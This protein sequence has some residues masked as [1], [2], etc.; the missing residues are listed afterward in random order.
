MD[1]TT[2]ATSDVTALVRAAGQG[3]Q[4]AWADL[5]DRYAPL[6]ASVVH[7]FRLPPHDAEDVLQTVWLRLVEHLGDLREPRALPMWI[8]TTTRNEC[9]RLLRRGQRS[10]PFDPLDER[11]PAA[12]A[13]EV[14]DLDEPLLK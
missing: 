1:G 2:E 4:T 3:D 6:V 14:V 11:E 9:L 8:I 13:V 5:V 12:L 7:G 10:R